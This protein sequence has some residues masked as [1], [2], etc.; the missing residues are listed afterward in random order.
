[1]NGLSA[2]V[3][4]SFREEDQPFVRKI[5][6]YL[7]TIVKAVPGF[8]WDHA[9]GAEAQ[10]VSAK[11][12]QKI[13]DKD[14]FIGI[15]SIAEYM[16]PDRSVGTALK[17]RNAEPRGSLWI[18]QEI[19][20]AIG[21]GMKI[22]LLLEK[23]IRSPG[24]LQS[25]LEY[26]NFERDAVEQCF[27]ALLQMIAGQRP[28]EATA[29]A[30]A[31]AEAPAAASSPA[32]EAKPPESETP[33]DQ[34]FKRNILEAAFDGT[35][36][37]VKAAV[38]AYRRSTPAPTERD[39][40]EWYVIGLDHLRY[41]GKGI[42]LETL[43][44][45]RAQHPQSDIIAR[46]LAAA[47]EALGESDAA[48]TEYVA[49]VTLS[50]NPGTKAYLLSSA[51]TIRHE[52]KKP[53]LA[54]DLAGRLEALIDLGSPGQAA[55]VAT[56]ATLWRTLGKFE[57]FC[58]LSELALEL[59]PTLEQER[60]TLAS[61]C[62]ER[63]L[64]SLAYVHYSTLVRTNAEHSGGWNNLWAWSRMRCNCGSEPPRPMSVRGRSRTHAPAA[65]SHTD[66]STSATWHLPS[67]YAKRRKRKA[68]LM[69]AWPPLR[70]ARLRLIG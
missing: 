41:R 36:E 20:L 18:T 14:L 61:A 51:A 48:A 29:A 44:E 60:F 15:C 69:S 65:T 70:D 32:P 64:I 30:G 67:R 57:R 19:G 5:L 45:L 6:D 21:R 12:L 39:V 7:T 54:R 27:P 55:V 46:S 33:G 4:H 28:R 16:V 50:E 26:I 3:G 42:T 40:A 38:E 2:F 22:I 47:F 8:S 24:G 43:R 35:L 37:D 49:A 25:D 58:A 11:V 17:L 1:M 59:D 56:A 10:Q 13:A 9:F 66:S 34:L 52:Q 53:D 31:S 23:G 63:E 68:D 62:S